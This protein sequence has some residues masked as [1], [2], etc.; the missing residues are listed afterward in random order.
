MKKNVLIIIIILSVYAPLFECLDHFGFEDASRFNSLKFFFNAPEKIIRFFFGDQTGGLMIDG[1]AYYRPLGS[2]FYFFNYKFFGFSARSLHISS[3]F[4]FICSVFLLYNITYTLIK[5][6]SSAFFAVI[7]FIL[8]PALIPYSIFFA[9]DSILMLSLFFILA[10]IYLYQKKK[11]ILYINTLVFCAFFSKEIAYTLPLILI[12]YEIIVNNSP[13]FHAIKKNILMIIISTVFYIYRIVIFNGLYH[14]SSSK[15]LSKNFLLKLSCKIIFLVQL[16]DSFFISAAIIFLFA[17]FFIKIGNSV[18][19]QKTV[20][21]IIIWAILGILPEINHY[22]NKKDFDS[23]RS[24]FTLTAP[25]S[26]LIAAMIN[27]IFRICLKNK[28]IL[29][30]ISFFFIFMYFI[31][32]NI[33]DGWKELSEYRNELALKVKNII[34]NDNKNNIILFCRNINS[35]KFP[36]SAAFQSTTY[37]MDIIYND[38]EYSNKKFH[39]NYIFNVNDINDFIKSDNFSAYYIDK[40]IKKIELPELLEIYS[41]KHSCKIINKL[42]DDKNLTLQN[43]E[44]LSFM[45]VN[46]EDEDLFK[47][48]YNPAADKLIKENIY[49]ENNSADFKNL[50]HLTDFFHY[51]EFDSKFWVDLILNKK[52]APSQEFILS[53]I[54]YYSIFYEIELFNKNQL[55]MLANDNFYHSKEL[56]FYIKLI[57]YKNKLIS[58][59]VFQKYIPVLSDIK[60]EIHKKM[61]LNSLIL[62]SGRY[63]FFKYAF[64]NKF[65]IS[66]ADNLIFFLHYNIK[67]L[68]YDSEI[69]DKNSFNHGFDFVVTNKN[70][71]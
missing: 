21:F 45:G 53:T 18:K 29:F 5:S 41:D 66:N 39:N 20:I 11:N 48:H 7:T 6:K 33:I 4:I 44:I 19:R 31:N 52:S 14:Y 15:I 58:D 49:S 22:I 27:N 60:S 42:L 9:V 8:Y 10:A 32:L 17:I 36:E 56:K 40:E 64:T 67:K 55:I 23:Y 57:L 50:I 13:V 16:Y 37:I 34:S 71:Q 12:F 59:S 30:L 70:F 65:F 61:I 26:I 35:K 51:N 46:D 28:T 38:F 24:M 69:L 62:N 63:N 68:L 43:S 1:E 54:L 2:I 25:F 3:L 47:N